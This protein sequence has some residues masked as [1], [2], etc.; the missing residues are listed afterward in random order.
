[1]S[2]KALPS[3]QTISWEGKDFCYQSFSWIGRLD[4]ISM[5]SAYN[6]STLELLRRDGLRLLRA[7]VDR[8]EISF[9]YL[10]A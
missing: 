9:F 2:E 5:S 3:E 7:R 8:W 10:D 4:S 1:M 6:A